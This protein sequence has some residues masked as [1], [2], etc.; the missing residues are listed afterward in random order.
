[1]ST[2]DAGNKAASDEAERARRMRAFLHN[3][4]DN[5]RFGDSSAL[6]PRPRQA[7]EQH[8]HHRVPRPG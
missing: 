8:R 1:M 6:A 3:P 4:P 7:R 5:R 2:D